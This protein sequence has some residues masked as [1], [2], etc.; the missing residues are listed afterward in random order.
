MSTSS[1][2]NDEVNMGDSH[3]IINID[4]IRQDIE[5]VLRQAEDSL[6][7]FLDEGTDKSDLQAC[8]DSIHQI[9]GSLK[10]FEL[11]GAARL[12]KALEQLLDKLLSGSLQSNEQ[13]WPAIIQA[14]LQLPRYLNLVAQNSRE[15]PL[16]LMGA[17]NDIRFA[18]GE[19]RLSNKDFFDFHLGEDLPPADKHIQKRYIA[20]GE[21]NIRKIRQVFQFA[22]IRLIRNEEIKINLSRVLNALEFIRQS[23]QGSCVSHLWNIATA[24][25]EGLVNDSI[26]LNPDTLE[27]L[28][29][30]DGNIKLL[31]DAGVAGLD[32]KPEDQLLKS[33]LYFIANCEDNAPH[34]QRI[35]NKYHLSDYQLTADSKQSSQ[36]S[37]PDTITTKVVVGLLKEEL[38]RIK[39]TVDLHMRTEGASGAGLDSLGPGMRRM[40]STL[41]LLNLEAARSTVADQLAIVAAST[42][43]K[44][45]LSSEQLLQM[46]E[47]LL[48]VEAEL[49]SVAAQGCHSGLDT[50]DEYVAQATDAVIAAALTNLHEAKEAIHA[51]I[52]HSNDYDQLE[53]VPALL[54]ETYGSLLIISFNTAGQLIFSVAQY[55][56][57]EILAQRKAP[58]EQVMD[59]LAE[60]ISRVEHYLEMLAEGQWADNEDLNQAKAGMASLGYP[61]DQLEAIVSDIDELTDTICEADSLIVDADESL[62]NDAKMFPQHIANKP[63]EETLAVPT[64]TAVTE[65]ILPAQEDED[66]E[67]IEIFTEEVGEVFEEITQY[68]PVYTA[69]NSNRSALAE[70][71]RGFHTLKGSG[72]MVKAGDFAE[73]ACSIEQLLN[74]VLDG[75]ISSSSEIITLVDQVRGCMPTLLEQFKAKQPYNDVGELIRH[76][77]CLAAGEIYAE[78]D[79]AIDLEREYLEEDGPAEDA[80]DYPSA[81][82]F[83]VSESDN[84]SLVSFFI[85]E[86]KTHLDVVSKFL[87]TAK[88]ALTPIPVSDTLIR[89]FHTLKG[90]AYTIEL[91]QIGKVASAA[92]KLASALQEYHMTVAEEALVLFTEA[93]S[94]ISGAVY[95]LLKHQGGLIKDHEK[96]LAKFNAFCQKLSEAQQLTISPIATFVQENMEVTCSARELFDQWS[97]KPDG[98]S[99]QL[100]ELI[101]M[102]DGISESAKVT[103]LPSLQKLTEAIAHSYA[104]L[105]SGRFEA[106]QS[107][108]DALRQAHDG[109]LRIIDQMVAG[110]EIDSTATLV[111]SLDQAI[112]Q[113]QAA[114]VQDTI[115]EKTN[116]AKTT[117]EVAVQASNLEQM[118]AQDQELVDIFLEEAEE[119]I[120]AVA[121][122]KQHWVENPDDLATVNDL[123][124][125][126][127]T[128][129]GGARMAGVIGMGDLSHAIETL[130][131]DVTAGKLSASESLF[132]LLHE[133]DDQ[134]TDMLNEIKSNH[135]CVQ[136]TDL[137]AKVRHFHETGE[138]ATEQTQII[139]HPE[140]SR[141]EA[142]VFDTGLGGTVEGDA[143]QIEAFFTESEYSFA[144]LAEKIKQSAGEKTDTKKCHAKISRL[145]ADISERSLAV[146]IHEIA[147]LCQI[148]M[149]VVKNFE[150]DELAGPE[151]QKEL[152]QW[153]ERIQTSYKEAKES[154]AEP[155]LQL[156]SKPVV[157]Q[158]KSTQDELRETSTA[159][160]TVRISSSLLEKLVGLAGETSVSRSRVE[161]QVSNFRYTIT[162]V[163]ATIDRLREQLRRL[164]RETEAQ[165]LFRQ[166]REGPEHMGFD[167]LEMD[168]YSR[169]QELSRGLTESTSDLLD[170]K[171]TLNDR[172]RYTENLL[173]AQSRI[174]TELQEG[175]MKTRMV[176]FSRMVPRLRR[177]VRQISGEVGKQIVFRLKNAEAELDRTLLD[178]MSAPLEH[179]LRNAVDHGIE[180]AEQRDKAG[181]PEKGVIE[182][183]CGRDGS[184]VILRLSDDGAGINIET[185]RSKAIERN[186]M[187]EDSE[188]SDREILQ[189][190]LHAGFSTAKSVTQISG[191]GVGMDVVRSEIKRLNGSI[192]IDSTTGKG[193]VFTI[194]LP[195]TVAMNRAL[196]VTIGEEVY[197]LPLNSIEGVVRVSPYELEEYYRADDSKFEYAGQAYDLHY[198]G[199][200]LGFAN[201]LQMKN[202]SLPLPVLLVRTAEKTAAIQVD[203]I[204]G[205]REIVVKSLGPQLGT[206][207]GM[208]GATILGDGRVV[209]ILDMPA[210]VRSMMTAQSIPTVQAPEATKTSENLQVM[211]VDDSVT[212]RK[213]ASRILQRNSMDVI[214]AKDGVE[215]VTKLQDTLPDIMLM[216]IEMPRMDG[217]ELATLMRHDDRLR[218]VPIIM[219]T[220]RTG[221]KHRDRAKEIGVDRFM[222]KPFQEIELLQ[223]I[224]ELTSFE[225]PEIAS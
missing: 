99:E 48:F 2:E 94:L 54:R 68:W 120:E 25:V 52:T 121:V 191:R 9:H 7:M 95:S 142:L 179:M 141:G 82:M 41:E 29:K 210:M 178:H 26:E 98:T 108:I 204:S 24:L 225:I 91:A 81:E 75:A 49:D 151:T 8:R 128:L 15:T 57:D 125:N 155:L 157:P 73:L 111:E 144:Q 161:Q 177:I 97:P 56:E 202:Q 201:S 189:F 107:L 1:T 224:A 221:Q 198:L 102:M 153:L 84:E 164:D 190:I 58:T 40:A 35:K 83:E 19:S 199:E 223:A 71:R 77:N 113:Q 169:I 112:A 163:D 31:A 211:V 122:A 119:I 165:I 61:V 166:E 129:K 134:L 60:A 109:M 149:E 152:A 63:F 188:L 175:L 16:L 186:L 170:L 13:I 87:D 140:D 90:S 6:K 101:E 159:Q 139:I 88:D 43:K 53:Q 20:E 10:I 168:R 64:E 174:N 106:N 46:A 96:L 217:F 47:A 127:H 123:Q 93:R 114:T 11:D 14:F 192:E 182:L 200:Y 30:T 110:L 44:Q 66:E 212:V 218:D 130:Y 180:S 23:T 193:S 59:T 80:S 185:V 135:S 183:Y 28:R 33:M 148:F 158:K 34:I 5:Q 220:S 136:A 173:L 206:I 137:I 154:A 17:I 38:E 3:N 62:L 187:A 45:E 74:R 208:S 171:E 79:T 214:V 222:G 124:R 219:V 37:A 115:N 55:V 126:L 209:L 12:T 65:E 213:V 67:I 103:N 51:F 205:S 162:E 117:M 18:M 39:D 194:R 197:A 133:C 215:A 167:P 160:D 195:F 27:L 42:E 70:V 150:P 156:A 105:G 22:L 86:S 78:V 203:S 100:T 196:M 181:K 32:H 89:A 104:S 76:A 92:E 145:I 50:R 143:R 118:D 116:S 85:A 131:Q 138:I 72:R 132:E 207:T 4:W 216:D 36:I 147:D 69:D 176:P 184:D 21:Q 172:A 146:G